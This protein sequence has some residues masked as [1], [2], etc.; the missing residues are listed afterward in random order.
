MFQRS[1]NRGALLGETY[2]LAFEGAR[3]IAP[4]VVVEPVAGPSHAPGEGG[5]FEGHDYDNH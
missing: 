3:E 5:E 2:A 1:L 4:I